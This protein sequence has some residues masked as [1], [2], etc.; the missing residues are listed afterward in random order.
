MTTQTPATAVHPTGQR[1]LDEAVARLREAARELARLP[2]P[3]RIALAR[4]M[5]AGYVRV[6]DQLVRAACA[7]K[8]VPLDTP[9]EAEEW[10]TGPWP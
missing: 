3:D 4:T 2:L 8:G 6:A 1:R 5:Q 7:A 10:A 9:S